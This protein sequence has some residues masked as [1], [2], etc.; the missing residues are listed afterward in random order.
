M[1]NQVKTRKNS[2][3]DN[4]VSVKVLLLLLLLLLLML[5]LLMLLLMLLLNPA[6]F[7]DSIMG[8]SWTRALQNCHQF[9]LQVGFGV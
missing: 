1:Q 6:S 8:H 3:G 7:T 4:V 5:L 9:V 2:D